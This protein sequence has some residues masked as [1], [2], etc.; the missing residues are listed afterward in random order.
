MMNICTKKGKSICFE[1]DQEKK[2][3]NVILLKLVQHLN[4]WT[5]AL[6]FELVEAILKVCFDIYAYFLQSVT[7]P[8]FNG[9]TLMSLTW[10]TRL[11]RFL[12]IENTEL[13]VLQHKHSVEL[14]CHGSVKKMNY[15]PLLLSNV[16]VS[17]Y[18][19]L[20][21]FQ[22]LKRVYKIQLML[23]E[24]RKDYVSL[25]MH[26]LPDIQTLMNLLNKYKQEAYE[27]YQIVLLGCLEY[28]LL[29]KLGGIQLSGI[30]GSKI[31]NLLLIPF[32]DAFKNM[33]KMNLLYRLL[34]VLVL[35]PVDCN[36]SFMLR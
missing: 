35:L 8:A 10:M 19:L 32:F 11:G 4:P 21:L 25:C 16:L 9:P 2:Y 31:M 6:Q 17:Y 5:N 12:A 28:Y 13:I 18:G 3:N 23:Q 33:R 1:I 24:N 14:L 15:N 29:L 34:S 27:V 26:C 7:I 20:I 22:S 30:K 36:V